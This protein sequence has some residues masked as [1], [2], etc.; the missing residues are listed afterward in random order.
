MIA[1]NKSDLAD[2]SADFGHGN[3]IRDFNVVFPIVSR[4][5][6]RIFH[7]VRSVVTASRPYDH[8]FF[9]GDRAGGSDVN[10]ARRR[11]RPCF[12]HS[13]NNA[14]V[15]YDRAAAVR[16]RAASDTGSGPRRCARMTRS[17]DIA[18]VYH[19]RTRRRAVSAADT[20]LSVV[21]RGATF[22]LRLQRTHIT[23][24]RLRVNGKFFTVIIV[25]R[26]AVTR[27]RCAVAKNE[28]YVAVHADTARKRFLAGNNVP[29]GSPIH[30]IG[31]TRDGIDLNR[32]CHSLRYAILVQILNGR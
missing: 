23:A 11:V 31:R 28:F 24:R 5:I 7:N 10:T 9:D 1:C 17:Y 14:A 30:G 2:V 25:N 16:F 21:G 19:D 12:S 27:Q 18:A 26:N 8:A 29:P 3:G 4:V 22:Y 20:R 13:F 6:I 32:V 15:Y